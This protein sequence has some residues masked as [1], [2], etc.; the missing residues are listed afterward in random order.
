MKKVVVITGASD[1]VGKETAILLSKEY[2]LA[3]CGRSKE[4]L[5]DTISKLDHSCNV[6]PYAFDMQNDDSIKEFIRLVTN[7]FGHINALINVAGANLKKECIKD[8]SIDLLKNMMQLNCYAPLE[9]IQ[10][11][12]PVLLK[13]NNSHIINILSSTCLFSNETMGGYTCSKQG[14]N[15]LVQILVK[16]AKK[17]GIHVSNIYPGGIDTNF[18]VQQKPLYLRPETV[19][20]AIKYCLENDDGSIQELVLRPH[21]EDNF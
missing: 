10:G 14:F 18:R 12:Y 5:E 15:G 13:E 21:V 7:N 8:M 4:K 11:L 19:A 20:K 2:D 17:D 16:E 3:I 6:F 1:G 9:L